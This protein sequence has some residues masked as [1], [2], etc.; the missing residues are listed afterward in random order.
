MGEIRDF[1]PGK[2]GEPPNGVAPRRLAAIIA[3]VL[4][5]LGVPRT[6]IVVAT[7]GLI[8][9]S[10]VWLPATR[11]WNAAGHLAWS[12]SVYLFAS[13]LAFILDWTFASHLG[14]FSTA[15]GVLL[16]LL[17]LFAALLACAYLWELCDALGT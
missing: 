8:A 15:G 2:H 17:E 4:Y 16:W 7:A 14:P 9:M 10:L 11:R 13:Y 6:Q 1:K 3:G 12:S 5:L